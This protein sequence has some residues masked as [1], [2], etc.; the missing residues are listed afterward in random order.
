MPARRVL[1]VE[2]R[3]FCAGVEAAVKAL[4]W[5]VV[6]HGPPVY[7]VHAIV[8]NDEVVARFR[9]LGVVFVDDVDAVP[10]GCPLVLSAHGSAPAVVARAAA[11]SPVVVDTVCPLVAKVHHEIR[12]R[13]ARGAAIVYVGHP[14]HDE[15]EAA[16]AI[17]PHA[18]TVVRDAADVAA[19]PAPGTEVALLAQTTLGMQV[20]DEV[21]VAARARF[22]EVWTPR[23]ADLCFATTNRQRA[24]V[25]AA[26]RCDAIVVVGSRSSANTAA[27]VDAARSAGCPTVVRVDG[28]AELPDGAVLHGT[29]GVTA[30]ASAPEPA[31]R[32][33]VAALAPSDGVRRFAP[34]HEDEY[35][36][37][38]ASLRRALDA[39]A[40]SARLSP[41]LGHALAHDRET[42]ALDLLALVEQRLHAGSA[43]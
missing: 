25:A 17:A 5:T 15:T 13:A 31:V 34:V 28:P 6:L 2:P 3:G 20:W 22:D 14:G 11:R 41:E 7:C 27:L 1:L 24:V 38:P 43:A 37:L 21:R 42:A 40:A 8:H 18:T 9:S 32:A 10:W 29:V 23:R 36:P 35:F 16:R 12:S 39:H 30:G 26:D 19:V 4:A 33:V